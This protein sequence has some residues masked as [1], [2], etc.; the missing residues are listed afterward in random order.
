MKILKFCIHS[1]NSGP[2][3]SDD[4]FLQ[5]KKKK[6]KV[7]EFSKVRN[8]HVPKKELELGHGKLYLLLS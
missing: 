2:R 8:G 7:L 1:Q 6:K 5:M 3:M 4:T